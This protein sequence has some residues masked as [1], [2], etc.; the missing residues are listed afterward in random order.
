MFMN[1]QF[2]TQ[3]L[4]LT[5]TGIFR[6]KRCLASIQN[7][8]FLEWTYVFYPVQTNISLV[9]FVLSGSSHVFNARRA[10]TNEVTRGRPQNTSTTFEHAAGVRSHNSSNSTNP[11]WVLNRHRSFADL[12]SQASLHEGGKGCNT[13]ASEP[14]FL[15]NTNGTMETKASIFKQSSN[16]WI[17]TLQKM[18]KQWIWQPFSSLKSNLCGRNRNRGPYCRLSFYFI[19]HHAK[20]SIWH[21]GTCHQDCCCS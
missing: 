1:L 4:F 18:M 15:L 11:Q 21:K 7:V 6:Q 16:F 9:V 3:L 19:A 14:Y 17:T 2:W 10:V 12:H 5:I 13:K 8:L 20:Y